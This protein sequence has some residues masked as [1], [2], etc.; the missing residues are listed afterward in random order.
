MG[1]LRK[2]Y[3]QA[4]YNLLK[5]SECFDSGNWEECEH[6]INSF[7]NS[8]R[9]VTFVIQN[10]GRNINSKS[11]NPW[12]EKSKQNVLKAEDSI[13]KDLRN[14]SNKVGPVEISGFSKGV[15]VSDINKVNFDQGETL[16]ISSEFVYSKTGSSKPT[17]KILDKKGNEKLEIS[18]FSDFDINEDEFKINSFIE[19]S[20]EY[21]SRL[22]DLLEEFE[23]EFIY[24]K[25]NI[26]N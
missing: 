1:K 26:N 8:A 12:Y 10:I 6:Y 7:L 21:L 11:F 25:G 4:E 16:V 14:I 24:S 9:N 2:Q 22:L 20:K 19:S 5:I 18:A 15:S 23:R 13:F 3:K 17:A